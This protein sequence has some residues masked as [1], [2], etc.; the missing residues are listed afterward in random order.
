MAHR[1]SVTPFQLAP[2]VVVAV[3]V[4]CAAGARSSNDP[5]CG[6]FVASS[7][8]ELYCLDFAHKT[9]VRTRSYGASSLS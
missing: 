6:C 1:S 7:E 8:P 9:R 4:S 2:S 3:G 5:A